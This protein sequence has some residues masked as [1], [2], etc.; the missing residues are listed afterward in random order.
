MTDVIKKEYKPHF[1]KENAAEIGRKGGLVSVGYTKAIRETKSR[2]N[3]RFKKEADAIFNSLLDSAKGHFY[4][5][6]DDHGEMI[7]VYKKSPDIKAIKEL[8]DRVWGKSKQHIELD[9]QQE[10]PIQINIIRPYEERHLDSEEQEES[11]ALGESLEGG[12]L[13]DGVG[14]LD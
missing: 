10:G 5:L 2:L 6:V 4:E 1:T 14:H 8:L 7:K 13:H 9:F 11:L 3:E 12:P